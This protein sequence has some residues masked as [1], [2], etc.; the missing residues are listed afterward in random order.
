LIPRLKEKPTPT[1]HIHIAHTT[2]YWLASCP[3]ATHD[4]ALRNIHKFI[5]KEHNNHEIAIALRKFP[6]V[7]KWL[8]NEQINHKLSN[9]FWKN[10]KI[11]YAQ[12][13][14]TLKFRYAQHMGNHRKNIFW[15][16]KFQIAHYVTKMIE[17]HGPTYYQCANI[18]T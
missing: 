16:L 18:L 13:T 14:Q 9:H 1:P 8:A 5:I 3:T 2:P 12:I 10:N 4:G 7:E 17:I 15:P 11:S 6:Y